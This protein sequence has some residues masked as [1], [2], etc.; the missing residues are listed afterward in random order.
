MKTK[1]FGVIVSVAIGGLASIGA[2][3]AAT[4]P[5]SDTCVTYNVFGSLADLE[6]QYSAPYVVDP[7]PVSLGGTLY[8]DVTAGTVISADLTIPGFNFTAQSI[9]APAFAPLNNIYS[10]YTVPNVT[11]LLYELNVSS[12]SGDLGDT[13]Y[14]DFIVASDQSNPLI[15]SVPKLQQGL[16]SFRNMRRMEASFKNARALQLRFSQSLARRRQRLS[17]AIVRSTIQRLGNCT[18]PFAWSDRL[19]ISVSRRGRNLAS[20]LAKIGPWYALS[21]NSFS[22]N[23]N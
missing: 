9:S 5:V 17:H 21:A 13:G 7:G 18:N 8:I 1:L 12:L 10:Q 16:Q 23:G 4:C 6:L 14:I 3:N 22:R 2:A 11:G 15:E 20:A 19:T